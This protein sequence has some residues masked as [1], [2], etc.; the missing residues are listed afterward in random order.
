MALRLNK[1]K[2]DFVMGG[3]MLDL[4][5]QSCTVVDDQGKEYRYLETIRNEDGSVRGFRY[6][7][8]SAQSNQVQNDCGSSWVW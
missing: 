5:A 6:K 1:N 4:F 3:S 8:P 2:E 7:Y